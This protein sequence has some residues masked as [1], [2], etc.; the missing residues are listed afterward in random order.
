MVAARIEN[1]LKKVTGMFTTTTSLSARAREF[2]GVLEIKV[3]ENFPR[4]DYARIKCNIARRTG[5]RIYHL[6]FD[7]QY[8]AT[9]IEPE[10]GELYVARGDGAEHL[11]E[12]VR[13]CVRLSFLLTP[14]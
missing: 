10:R 8:D 4:D 11:S 3:E 5:E 14:P 12:E 13:R 9:E 6:P 1:P 2:A 7:Q